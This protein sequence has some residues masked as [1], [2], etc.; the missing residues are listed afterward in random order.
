M[1]SLV[2]FIIRVS[3]IAIPLYLCNSLALVFGGS[4][5]IDFGRNFFDGKPILGQGKTFRGTFSGI[6]FAVLGAFLLQAAFPQI[7]ELLAVDYLAYGSLLA[8]GAVLGD[9]AGSF[10]KR[11][12]SIERGKSVFLLDQL[13]FVLGGFVLGS[14]L[15]LPSALEMV[16][17]FAFTMLAH[18]LGNWIA[19]FVKM[20]KNPW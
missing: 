10:F 5:P 15:M 7:N 6:F 2:F 8:V 4:Y 13:D 11:R 3:L 19:F 18:V 16:F 14:V 20:K 9:F 12:L 1:S 17:L